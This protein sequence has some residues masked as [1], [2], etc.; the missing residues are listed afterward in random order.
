M[1]NNTSSGKET[2]EGNHP[3]TYGCRWLF[4]REKKDIL[5][6]QYQTHPDKDTHRLPNTTTLSGIG[7]LGASEANLKPKVEFT[8]LLPSRVKV[9]P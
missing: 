7:C 1:G 4:P 5:P 2:E 6:V 8:D 3:E 9:R